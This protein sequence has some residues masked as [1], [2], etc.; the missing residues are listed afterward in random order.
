[1]IVRNAPANEINAKA[2]MK[3]LLV[4][5]VDEAALVDLFYDTVIDQLFRVG[6]FRLGDRLLYDTQNRFD[7]FLQR[8]GFPRLDLL[9]DDPIGFLGLIVIL[10][11]EEFFDQLN[12]LLPVRFRKMHALEKAFEKL[13]NHRSLLAQESARG[14]DAAA[15]KLEPQLVSLEHGGETSL[16][17]RDRVGHT[18]HRSVNGFG[19]EG[20]EPGGVIT[21][22]HDRHVFF[23]QAELLEHELDRVIRRRTEAADPGFF[24]PQ[25]FRLL[26]VRGNEERERQGWVVG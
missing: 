13:L 3:E 20:G 5:F 22:L 17:D 10:E 11:L 14:R 9:N 25:I 2:R 4:E 24:S 16:L 12:A 21:H 18:K 7:A 6:V 19:R 1:M 15:L 26:D 23:H 8:I